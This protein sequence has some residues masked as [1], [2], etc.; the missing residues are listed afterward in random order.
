MLINLIFSNDFETD[1]KHF[2][3][4]S[5]KQIYYFVDEKYTFEDDSDSNESINEDDEDEN[6][7]DR[8]FWKYLF[9][10]RKIE[11]RFIG[12]YIDDLGPKVILKRIRTI[13][14][15]KTNTPNDQQK[16]ILLNTLDVRCV[17]EGPIVDL[18]NKYEYE[19]DEE[20]GHFQ[21]ARKCEIIKMPC[22]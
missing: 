9:G 20:I 14:D 5:I 10:A 21:E 19:A 18:K 7:D 3:S 4:L 11:K 13:F 17:Q 8:L 16:T 1:L 22:S 15:F 2:F 6:E 12:D